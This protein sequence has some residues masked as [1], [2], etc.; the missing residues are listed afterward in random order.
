M[1]VAQISYILP[2]VAKIKR[3]LK[4]STVICTV[5][6]K[7]GLHLGETA[8]QSFVNSIFNK[9]CSLFVVAVM[10]ILYVR[11]GTI[12]K[13]KR[14][15]LLIGRKKQTFS[16]LLCA[17]CVFCKLKQR[18]LNL[19]L[20]FINQKIPALC[21]FIKKCC[22]PRIELRTER[23]INIH[24]S[25]CALLLHEKTAVELINELVN[26]KSNAVVN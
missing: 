13:P 21:C 6:R 24:K 20:C 23:I 26:V 12:Q 14:S 2:P 11:P 19:A 16:G 9:S 25:T 22:D 10:H 3:A 18:L 1:S 7:D 15:T 17:L 5:K 4:A 8:N